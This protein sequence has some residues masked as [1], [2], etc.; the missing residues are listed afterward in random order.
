M[1]APLPIACRFDGSNFIPLGHSAK[2]C[3]TEFQAHKLYFL[4]PIEDRSPESHRHYFAAINEAW[5]NLPEDLAQEYPTPEHLRKKALIR[6]GYAD[7]QSIVCSSTAEALRFA[8]FLRPIDDYS[9]VTVSRNVVT[10]YAAKSQSQRAMGKAAFQE[11]KEKVLE[12]VAGMIGV[13]RDQLTKAV[14]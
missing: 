8:A 11:S 13:E 3:R 9:V 2:R 1:S 6:A 14:S 10:R 12:I 5:A 7:E 4:A